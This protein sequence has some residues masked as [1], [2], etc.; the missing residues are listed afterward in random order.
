MHTPYKKKR[1]LYSESN[2]HGMNEFWICFRPTTRP[3]NPYLFNERTNVNLL[4]KITRKRYAK[5]IRIEEGFYC[6]FY[7]WICSSCGRLSRV[8]RR[9]TWVFEALKTTIFSRSHL[10]IWEKKFRPQRSVPILK[11]INWHVLLK[12]QMLTIHMSNMHETIYSVWNTDQAVNF[13]QFWLEDKFMI[14]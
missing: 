4:R 10:E 9:R 11:S 12:T 1:T 7:F 2:L 5:K 3:L 6:I 14:I 8:E 13:L